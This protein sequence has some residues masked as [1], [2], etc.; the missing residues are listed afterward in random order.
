MSSSSVLLP[1]FAEYWPVRTYT[2]PHATPELIDEAQTWVHSYSP[3]SQHALSAFFK[4][5]FGEFASMTYPKMDRS[6]LRLAIDN[7]YMFFIIDEHTDD[8]D[9]VTVRKQCDEV[10]YAFKNSH[11][12]TENEGVL[13]KMTRDFWNRVQADAQMT[14]S[15]SARFIRHYEKYLDSVHA[16]AVDRD[17]KYILPIHEYMAL[18]RT[19]I[20]ARV[21]FDYILV[22]DD[23]PDEIYNHPHVSKILD[24]AIDLIIYTN[25][26]YSFFVERRSVDPYHN[27]VVVVMKEL[28][29]DEQRA[30]DYVGERFRQA[31]AAF[32]EL[33]ATLPE[34]PDAI[35]KTLMHFIDC[36]AVWIDG[37][38]EWSFISERYFGS[39][40]PEIRVHRTVEL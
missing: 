25:D 19:G 35:K 2:N 29:L 5:K 28:N 6:A 15:T 13:G 36:M 32:F 34:F 3:F 16:Q 39:Q 38:I 18:R 30:I 9:S 4:C 8:K 31:T 40:G 23:L 1:D 12:P 7:M 33:Q 37:H 10:I 21:A 11:S 14:P 17:N 27:L 26:V 20:A 22:Q 24:N